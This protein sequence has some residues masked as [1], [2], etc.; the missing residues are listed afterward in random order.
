MAVGMIKGQ[1]VPVAAVVDNRSIEVEHIA[2]I[3][4]SK[5]NT[6]ITTA[7]V[8]SEGERGLYLAGELIP[9]EED[10]V[11][12]GMKK[13]IIRGYNLSLRIE[14]PMLG[15]QFGAVEIPLEGSGVSST[16]AA[17]D[18]VRKFNPS[19]SL[20]Q[21]FISSSIK[22]A[23]SYYSENIGSIIDK[24]KMLA[25][26]GDYDAGIALLW[27]C[28][29]LPSI[30]EEVY[31]AMTELYM[32]KQNKECSNLLARAHSAYSLK[33]YA[34]AE[35]YIKAIDTDSS[36][37]GEARKLSERIGGEVRQEEK[38]RQ[39]RIDRENERRFQSAE[40][41]RSRRFQLE[42]RRIAAIENVAKSYF[43]GQRNAYHYYIVR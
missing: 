10:Y 27:G 8:H 16:K 25:K 43:D 3:L 24:A 13:L 15:L 12:T 30:H 37:A 14:Q 42:K 9:T 23:D 11:D 29:N 20:T 6:A 19:A 41:E 18:A 28:P 17:I 38:E 39:K 4:M 21:N 35:E 34:E 5:L 31:K 22:K 26:G 1:D 33:K 40:D 32:A 36:C 2:K 7:G